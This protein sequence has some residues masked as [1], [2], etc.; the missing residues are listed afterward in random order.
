M[1][2]PFLS[3]IILAAALLGSPALQAQS[4]FACQPVSNITGDSDVSNETGSTTIAAYFFAPPGQG[5]QTVNGVTFLPFDVPDDTDTSITFG[6]VTLSSSWS[7]LSLYPT[8]QPGG[9]FASLTPAYQ[10]ILNGIA[11]EAVDVTITLTGLTPN[12]AY[13]FQ[14]WLNMSNDLAN[15]YAT[16]I[17]I[18]NQT[19]SLSAN[20]TVEPGGLGQ[21]VTGTF[22]LDKGE[23]DVSFTLSAPLNSGVTAIQVRTVP[24]PGTGALLGAG[25][26]ILTAVLRRTRR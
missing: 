23:T 21:Y 24:E 15:S 14:Y 5:Q 8:A 10:G 22:T 19:A 20:T 9:Q 18:N 25:V 6:N 4:D 7:L 11:F 3:T 17:A 16:D 2:D 1:K 26:L 12:Q 13:V